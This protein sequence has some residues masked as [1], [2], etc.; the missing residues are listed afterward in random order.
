MA[1]INSFSVVVAMFLALGLVVLSPGLASRVRILESISESPNV[2]NIEFLV[3]CAKKLT[4]DCGE[5]IFM[6]IF[7][8]SSKPVSDNCCHLLVAMGRPCHNGLM[9]NIINKI[10]DYKTNE[11]IT[12]PRGVEIWNKCAL[13]AE[14][15]SED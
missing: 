5:S 8:N 4:P 3:A 9:T 2:P 14:K 11:T 12:R 1:R 13:V 10:P 7:G 15:P 6:N